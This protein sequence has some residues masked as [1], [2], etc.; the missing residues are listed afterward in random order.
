MKVSNI[1][2]SNIQKY[3]KITDFENFFNVFQDQN[4]N[5]FYNLNENLYFQVDKTTL[6]SMVCDCHCFWPLLSYKIYGTTRLAWMLMKVN[7][8][9]AANVFDAKEPG[10]IIYYVPKD[11]VEGIVADLNDFEN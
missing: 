10:D 1:D 5:N 9:N 8:V 11:A 7:D 2:D 4:G 6:P 3:L